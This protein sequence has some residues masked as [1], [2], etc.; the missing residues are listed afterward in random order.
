MKAEALAPRAL[1]DVTVQYEVPVYQRPYVWNEDNQWSPLWE[2]VRRLADRLI[3]ARRQNVPVDEESAHFLGAVV[4]KSKSAF[5]G[6]VVRYEVVD[7]QQRLTTLQLLLDAARAELEDLDDFKDEAEALAELTTNKA[8]RFQGTEKQFKLWPS[9]GDREA[10]VA[11]MSGAV[12]GGG[13]DHRVLEAHHYFRSEIAQWLSVTDPDT[14]G[15]TEERVT[16]LTDVLETKLQVVSI[17]LD[18]TDDDQ[19]I[20]ETLNDRG[21]PLLKADLI[22]NW[23]F[24]RGDELNADVEKWADTYWV[25]FEDDWW[26]EE[27]SQGRHLRSRIDTF[28]QYWLTMRTSAEVLTDD[29]FAR[30]RQYGAKMM[31]SG[32]EAEQ[33]LQQLQSDSLLYR[34]LSTQ[35]GT[36]AVGRFYDTVVG[37]FEL[38]TFVPLLMRLASS[39]FNVPPKQAAVALDAMESW[40]VRR[41]LLRL[42]MKDVNKMVVSLLQSVRDCEDQVVGDRLKSEL[43]GQKANTRYWPGDKEVTDRIPT[44]RMYG[45]IRQNRLRV[46]L[47][48]VEQQLRTERH[49]SVAMQGTL[50]IE[51]VFPQGW[52]RHWETDPPRTEE[53]ESEVEY[54]LNCLGNLTLVTNKLNGSLSNRPWTDEDAA[55]VD[56]DGPNPGIGKRSLL[57]KFSLMVLNKEIVEDHPD[58][59][60]VTDIRARSSHLARKVCQAWPGPPIADT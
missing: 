59:W 46:V 10:F 54:E 26:R 40:V 48:G 11:A 56:L 22:K 18:G 9:R 21:T 50:D 19:L 29:V 43:A 34:K 13:D 38:A 31:T 7:G 33:L 27:V 57:N 28:L 55:R 42:T 15:S 47:Q 30:F 37:T 45:N 3:T 25:D 12:T 49:E 58:E 35:S 39:A 5:S 32:E 51:H 60:T 14:L 17:N 16:A 24:S 1:F 41:T 23:V 2:D 6:D 44:L 36:D 53:E 4:L 20:F 52:R 8:R